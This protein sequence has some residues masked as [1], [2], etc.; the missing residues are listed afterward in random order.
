MH[1]IKIPQVKDYETIDFRQ[2]ESGEEYIRYISIEGPIIDIWK[3]GEKSSCFYW[4]IKRIPT[5]RNAISL[6]FPGFSRDCEYSLG[7]N[8]WLKGVLHG[9]KIAPELSFW[10][11][12]SLDGT[13]FWTKFCR[14]EEI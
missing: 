6:D 4:I 5:M 2:V 7:G 14:I 9:V 3:S 11:Q 12:C 13:Y 10:V 8:H 1:S